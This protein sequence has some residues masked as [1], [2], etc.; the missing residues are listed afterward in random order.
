MG[1]FGRCCAGYRGSGGE[2]A[3]RWQHRCHSRGGAMT[4]QLEKIHEAQQNSA[5]E[6]QNAVESGS[7]EEIIEAYGKYGKRF[8]PR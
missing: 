7:D 3:A 6:V 4:G 1:E 5:A 8:A 2:A